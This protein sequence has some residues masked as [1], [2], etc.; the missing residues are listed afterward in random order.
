MTY[1]RIWRVLGLFFF[2]RS[3]KGISIVWFLYFLWRKFLFLRKLL[4]AFPK[5]NAVTKDITNVSTKR[6]KEKNNSNTMYLNLL[7]MTEE[8]RVLKVSS[9][10]Q[11]AQ[12][13]TEEYSRNC[14]QNSCHCSKSGLK[15]NKNKIAAMNWYWK[16]DIHTRI[17]GRDTPQV[18]NV[19]IDFRT[20]LNHMQLLFLLHC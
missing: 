6:K 13:K 18:W 17:K 19:S 1:K 4:K 9:E 15:S 2:F 16:Y 11:K 8:Q 20:E 10:L 12:M 7:F 14:L 5:V 3:S